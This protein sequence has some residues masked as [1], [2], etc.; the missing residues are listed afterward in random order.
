MTD[1]KPLGLNATCTDCGSPNEWTGLTRAVEPLTG[2][3]PPDGE[4]IR[5]YEIRCTNPTCRRRD[6]IETGTERP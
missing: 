4:Y 3:G 1:P 5:S 2:L 6:W